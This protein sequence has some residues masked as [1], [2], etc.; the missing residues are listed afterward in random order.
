M[1]FIIKLLLLSILGFSPLSGYSQTVTNGKVYKVLILHPFMEVGAWPTEFN[2]GLFNTLKSEKEIEIGIYY[3]YLG[4]E[5]VPDELSREKIINNLKNK[6]RMIRP[7]AVVSVFPSIHTTMTEHG[8]AIFPGIPKIY[9]PVISPLFDA[10]NSQ[11]D[12]FI[13]KSSSEFAIKQTLEN[14][15]TIY[16]ELKKLVVCSGSGDNDMPYLYLFQRIAESCKE[17]FDIQYLVGLPLDEMFRIISTLGPDSAIFLLPINRDN[18][19]VLYNTDRIFPRFPDI[20]SAPIF[21]FSDISFGHGVVGGNL[22][23]AKAYG[24]YSAEILLN[25]FRDSSFRIGEFKNTSREMYDWRQLKRWKIR[26]KL[27]PKDSS[28]YFKQ[29]D[30]FQKYTVQI[31]FVALI[32]IIQTFWIITMYVLLKKQK[33]NETLLRKNESELQ[34]SLKEKELLFREVHHRVKNNLAIIS[35]FLALQGMNLKDKKMHALLKSSQNRIR[36]MAMV[37]E[38]LYKDVDLVNIDVSVYIEQL[39]ASIAASYTEQLDE[40]K[41][42]LDIENIKMDIDKLIPVGLLI[43]E[44]VSN[45]F[46]YAFEMTEKPKIKILLRKKGRSSYNLKISDNG[47]GLPKNEI[48]ENGGTIGFLLI[49]TLIEQLQ[50]SHKTESRNGTEYNITF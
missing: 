4:L 25:I 13:I 15:K 3:E 24:E 42:D 32:L 16:P 8:E 11:P 30:F 49:N 6:A 44:I 18:N 28:I 35:S 21:T 39:V 9:V 41:I 26:E 33:K 2:S 27:L 36:S 37:H 23:S 19:Q 10:I 48:I 20:A 47:I 14:I 17:I 5:L 45:S 22:T 12:S 7:D 31:S 46:K 43:N 29:E 1:K 40:I 50:G 34:N 38:Q